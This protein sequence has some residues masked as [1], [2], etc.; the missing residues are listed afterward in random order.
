MRWRNTRG[1]GVQSPSAYRF[2]RYVVN[3]HYPYYAYE[4]LA[5]LLPSGDVVTRKLSQLYFRLA[6]FCQADCWGVVTNNVDLYEAYITAGCNKTK[7]IDCVHGYE[8]KLVA[9]SDVCVMTLEG[10][11]RRIFDTF[12]SSAESHKLLI[13][14]DIHATRSARRIWKEMIQD[15]RTVVSYDLYY[16][17]IIFFDHSKYKQH[18]LVNF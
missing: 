18:Y 8:L 6:N 9:Q 13:V 2:I 15:E 10:N 5:E 4:D 17:G 3:E 14:E 7:V 16:C 12:V 11:W 1:F